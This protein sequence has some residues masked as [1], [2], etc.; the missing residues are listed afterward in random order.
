MP[1]DR[2]QRV[3]NDTKM[4]QQIFDVRGFDELDAATFD[5]GQPASRQLDF[6]VEWVEARSEEDGH[7]AQRHALFA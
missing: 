4:R 6:Q 7:L 1:T 2:I 3:G 5:E